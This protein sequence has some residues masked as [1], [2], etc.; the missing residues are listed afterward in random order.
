MR[1]RVAS[2]KN[3]QSS[4]QCDLRA[5]ARRYIREE[6]AEPFSHRRMGKDCVAQLRIGQVCHHRR[7]HDGHN[8]AGLGTDHRKAEDA[9][10]TCADNGLHEALCLVCRRRPSDAG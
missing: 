2:E 7:L 1:R 8:F 4:G 9:V 3:L 5:G 6:V 10:V